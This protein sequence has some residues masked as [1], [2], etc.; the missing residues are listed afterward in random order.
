[1][2]RSRTDVWKS[3]FRVRIGI[4]LFNKGIEEDDLI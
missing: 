1:M 2:P 3:R 4:L